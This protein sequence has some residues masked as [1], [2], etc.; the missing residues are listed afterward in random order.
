[1]QQHINVNMTEGSE[2]GPMSPYSMSLVMLQLLGQESGAEGSRRGWSRSTA[3]LAS[4]VVKK[5]GLPAPIELPCWHC[6]HS[7]QAKDC[8]RTG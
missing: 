8:V 3:T 7:G 5:K 4:P 6:R 1:M 2:W